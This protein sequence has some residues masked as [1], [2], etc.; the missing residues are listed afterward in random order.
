MKPMDKKI[1]FIGPTLKGS[2]SKKILKYHLLTTPK[3]ISTRSCVPHI[4][5]CKSPAICRALLFDDGLK[6]PGNIAS[7]TII[8]LITTILIIP[9]PIIFSIAIK[10]VV[11]VDV[12]MS[13][14]TDDD[15]NICFPE[16]E[17]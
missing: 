1:R 17:G 12:D 16:H 4:T 9:I 14:Q 11:F 13:T 6:S 3:L 7:V 5:K 2:N 10:P 15:I 8:F